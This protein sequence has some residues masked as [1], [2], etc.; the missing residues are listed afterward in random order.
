MTLL[1]LYR[2]AMSWRGLLLWII[3]TERAMK[4]LWETWSSLVY[5][6][7]IS[8]H[9]WARKRLAFARLLPY[10]TTCGICRRLLPPIDTTMT[11]WT[12]VVI[13]HLRIIKLELDTALKSVNRRGDRSTHIQGTGSPYN[14]GY[15]GEK[16][17]WTRYGVNWKELETPYPRISG[18]INNV[19]LFEYLIL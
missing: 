7:C 6:L 18:N 14:V 5:I 9:C 12:W 4:W 19:P 1:L 15:Q 13:H 17:F 11:P 10:E 2:T 16:S 8:D 3:T